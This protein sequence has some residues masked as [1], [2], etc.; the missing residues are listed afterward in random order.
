MDRNVPRMAKEAREE[1]FEALAKLFDGV[2]SVEKTH[3][4]RYN[5]VRETLEAGKT[6]KGD[7]PQ[8]WKC[9]NCGYISNTEEAPEV[10]P[11]CAHP[12]LIL[13]AGASTTDLLRN[14]WPPEFPAAF[15][16]AKT[17]CVFRWFLRWEN[18]RNRPQPISRKR[19]GSLNSF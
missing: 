8:G 6:F 17:T 3:E 10:C 1:G 11:V 18:S 12:R 13:S 7:A 2:A 15:S 5:K 9:R 4:E 14:L 16:N 19:H